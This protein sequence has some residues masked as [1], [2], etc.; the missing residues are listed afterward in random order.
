MGAYDRFE[1]DA[2]RWLTETVDVYATTTTIGMGGAVV[3]DGNRVITDLACSIQPRSAFAVHTLLGWMPNQSH[4]MYCKAI[5][6]NGVPLDIK[7]GYVVVEPDGGRRWQVIGP[8]ELYIDPVTRKGH[9]YEI[10]LQLSL[11][12]R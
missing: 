12:V 3:A 4:S 11:A 8:P 7:H 2:A 10:A 6:E 5:D 9:H 1:T